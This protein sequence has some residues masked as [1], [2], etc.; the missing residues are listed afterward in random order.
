V[1]V[2]RRALLEAA[3]HAVKALEAHGFKIVRAQEG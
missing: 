3:H 2:G 1:D